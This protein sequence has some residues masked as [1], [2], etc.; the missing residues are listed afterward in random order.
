MTAVLYFTSYTR[1]M[2]SW[3]RPVGIATDYGWMIGVRIPEGARNFSFRH[4]VQT[5]SGAHAASYSMDKRGSFLGDK[6]A[7]A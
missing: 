6:A 2:K 5:G 3:N 1:I 7:E 4:S